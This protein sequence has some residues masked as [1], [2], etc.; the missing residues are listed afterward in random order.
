MN[1][2]FC[3]LFLSRVLFTLLAAYSHVLFETPLSIIIITVKSSPSGW[4]NILKWFAETL[5]WS[6]SLAHWLAD[7]FSSSKNINKNLSGPTFWCL[8]VFEWNGLKENILCSRKNKQKK[9]KRKGRR[10]KTY[11]V[12]SPFFYCCCVTFLFGRL[13]NK[14]ESFFRKPFSCFVVGHQNGNRVVFFPA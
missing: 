6:D 5:R 7:C 13:L 4:P 14:T 3:R 2:F 10:K 8:L 11:S 1:N 12:S 9:R